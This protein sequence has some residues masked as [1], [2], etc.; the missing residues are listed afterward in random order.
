MIAL[1]LCFILLVLNRINGFEWDISE[2]LGRVGQMTFSERYMF[3][4]QKGPEM[5]PQGDS[6]I[7]VDVDVETYMFKNESTRVALAIYSAEKGH[8]LDHLDRIC[9]DIY[10]DDH[11]EWALNVYRTVADTHYIGKAPASSSYGGYIYRV[12]IYFKYYVME[13]GWHNVQFKVCD[14]TSS[15]EVSIKVIRVISYCYIVI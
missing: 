12:S 11:E 1:Y 3:A 8:E 4:S 13:E 2:N 5:L 9:A 7:K 10:D 6:Y 15:T 14:F